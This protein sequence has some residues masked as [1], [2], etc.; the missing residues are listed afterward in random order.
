MRF[1][2]II[3]IL[4]LTIGPQQLSGSFKTDLEQ[5]NWDREFTGLKQFFFSAKQIGESMV[6]RR[7][8]RKLFF[9]PQPYPI[10]KKVESLALLHSCLSLGSKE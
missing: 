10:R 9:S 4:G 3:A 8:S 6:E 1:G 7:R 2:T 5:S